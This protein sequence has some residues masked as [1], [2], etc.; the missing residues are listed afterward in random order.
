M[1]LTASIRILETFYQRTMPLLT[2]QAEKVLDAL[3][4]EQLQQVAFRYT[5]SVAAMTKISHIIEKSAESPPG[6]INLHTSFQYASRVV[7]QQAIYARLARNV[8]G[9]WLYYDPDV[10]ESVIEEI[11]SA[12]RT[13]AVHITNTP[14]VNYWFVIAYGPGVYSL[15]MAQEIPAVSGTDRYY[16]GFYAF[17]PAMTYQTLSIL[18][19]IFPEQVPHPIAPE[20][21]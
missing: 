20:A 15:L 10:D 16:E 4:P 18:H 7:Q 19:Q 21:L 3:S 12:P 1:S 5:F 13:T 9:L 11:L 14:L 2:P 17:D 8:R 6:Q